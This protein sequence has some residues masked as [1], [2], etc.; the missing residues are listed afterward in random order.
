MLI[1]G[2]TSLN[3]LF[4]SVKMSLKSSSLDVL[5]TVSST[6]LNF[7]RCLPSIIKPLSNR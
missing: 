2:P 4:N 6:K 7:L 1:F 5:S 3:L